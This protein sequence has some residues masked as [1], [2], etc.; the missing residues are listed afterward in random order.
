MQNIEIE[1]QVQVE[2]IEPLREFLKAQA[3]LIGTNRQ[4]DEYFTPAH[5]DFI[6]TRP[7][8]EWLRL[9]DADG[10]YSINYKNWHHG[11]NGKS[12]HC[13]EYETP[14][15][16]IDQLRRIFSA[17]DIKPIVKVDKTRTVYRH[18]DYEISLDTV[19]GLGDFVEVEFKGG[20]SGDDAKRI[21]DE[22]LEFLKKHGVGEIRRN[23]VGYPFQ[24][25]FP[26]E[27]VLETL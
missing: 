16:D 25:L 19:E 26:D 17:I 22:M 6:A 20:A 27:V 10:T 12:N 5:R 8:A 24:L 1:I 18:E 11:A 4:V 13:D 14:V 2:N 9:R 15:G 7:T 21:T 3:K 23:Y